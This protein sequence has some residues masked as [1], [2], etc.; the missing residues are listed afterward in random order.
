VELSSTRFL[1][2]HR[3][4]ERSNLISA[5]GSP[6]PPAL[7]ALG[8]L[9]V[10]FLWDQQNLCGRSFLDPRGY[11]VSFDETDFVHLIKLKD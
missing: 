2:N 9:L 1:Y 3:L 6:A 8:T 4:T 7:L 10:L 11:R 5:R